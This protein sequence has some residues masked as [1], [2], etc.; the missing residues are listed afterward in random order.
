M[1]LQYKVDITM[2]R[3]GTRTSKLALAQTEIV[4]KKI[5]DAFPEEKIEIVPIIT[6]GDKELNKP[7]ASFGGK[8]VFTKEIEEKLL[9][10]SIDIAVHSAKDIPMECK[11]GLTLGAVIEREDPRDV[12]VTTSGIATKNMGLKSII[13]TSSLR[14]E[15]QIKSINP[16]LTVKSLRGNVPTRLEKLR[17]GFYDGIILAAAG[18]KRLGLDNEEDL[19]Y[20]YFDMEEFLPA[21][22]QGI[23]ALEIRKNTLKHVMDILNQKVTESI[24]LAEREFLTVLGGSCNSPCG[25][26]CKDE[27]EGF[28]IRGMYAK[29]G[30]HPIYA[31]MKITENRQQ[32]LLQMAGKL[33]NQLKIKKVSLVGAGPGQKDFISK[34]ALDCV[35]A[36]DVIIYDN[37]ISPSILNKAKLDAELI[38]VGK[39]SNAHS[40]KQ[41]NINQLLITKALEGHYVVRLKGGDPF[42]FGRGGEEALALEAKEIP[43][44][45]VCGISSSYSVPALAGIPV[46]HRSIS[47]SVHIVTGHEGNHKINPIVDYHTLAKET[48]TLVFLMGFHHL[49]EITGQLISYGKDKETPVAVIQSGG[50]A[51][52]RVIKGTLATI[53]SKVKEANLGTP[54][55]IV[56]GNVVDL[57]EKIKCVEE[58]PLS[59]KRIL[60]TGTRNIATELEKK[61][62]PLGAETVSISLIETNLYRSEKTDQILQ[63][64]QQ[65]QWIVFV[66]VAGV[67]SF[68]TTLNILKIDR[69]TLASVKFAVVGIS[70]AKVLEEYGYY[71]DFVPSEYRSKIL[72]KEWIPQLKKDDKV[73]LVRGK[74]GSNYLENCL[75]KES[76]SYD[77][78]YVYETIQD[79]R[80][81]DEINRNYDTMDYVIITSGFGGKVLAD[82]LEYKN[83]KCKIVAIGPET[84]RACYNAGLS[85]QIVAREY[86]ADGIVRAI[87]Q[88]VIHF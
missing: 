65:Y 25:I 67:R 81:I 19:F 71:C 41:E 6:K 62:D 39:R 80:R 37:L 7:L 44:E 51:R 87:L 45:I 54:A 61:L 73:L 58:L 12:M 10:G 33:A 66:S 28:S 30:I 42:I 52:Q 78:S 31:S 69:R 3:I 21:A 57:Q 53:T 75:A 70:T 14:R 56:I 4:K 72:A 23:L 74:T 15:L 50:T 26:Y 32:D 8:G 2:I 9:D 68:F 5:L 49:E 60:L 38:Y 85:V 55:I 64:L 17:N 24:L 11:K 36:A 35:K 27:E 18:L 79:N 29:D 82:M 46:T 83:S 76:I 48:G 77:I 22:G 43:Y 16:H 59:G 63:Q 86:N 84:A 20:E 13:G 40:M 34:K 1:G 88:D 47:S